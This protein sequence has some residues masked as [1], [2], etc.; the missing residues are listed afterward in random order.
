MLCFSK[1]TFSFLSYVDMVIQ[2]ETEESIEFTNISRE[3]LGVLNDYIH[4]TLIPAM[5]TDVD[6]N[7]S[8]GDGAVAV[9]V[10]GSDD[11]E[12]DSETES[13]GVKRDRPLRAAS[14]T[15]RE[16]TR[17]HFDQGTDDNESSDEEDFQSDD[18]NSASDSDDT[19]RNT[20]EEAVVSSDEEEEMVTDGEDENIVR[21]TKKPRVS[22]DSEMMEQ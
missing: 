18:S 22:N 1:Q 20:D 7:C 15:A 14:K 10:V 19:E 11:C 6:G 12:E 21:H 2:L 13:T 16:A 4:K 9:E 5:Q 17:A 8:D 3:Q